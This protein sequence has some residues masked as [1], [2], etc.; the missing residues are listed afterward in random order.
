[1][2]KVKYR[3]PI[4]KGTNVQVRAWIDANTNKYVCDIEDEFAWCE[5]CEKEIRLEE[6]K[7]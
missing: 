7:D 1:M 6:I 4:C 5:N 3:C 2:K